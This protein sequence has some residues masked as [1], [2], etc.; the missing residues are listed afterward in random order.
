MF[1]FKDLHNNDLKQFKIMKK[2]SSGFKEI[3]MKKRV[4]NSQKMEKDD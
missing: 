2:E 3:H 4:V 1:E